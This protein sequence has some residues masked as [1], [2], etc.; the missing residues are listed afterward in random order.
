[1][2]NILIKVPTFIFFLGLIAGPCVTILLRNKYPEY[3]ITPNIIA[4]KVFQ[5]A[6]ILT[7]LISVVSYFSNESKSAKNNK[8]IYA[9]L[10]ISSLSS[11]SYGFAWK[12]EFLFD[13]FIVAY[14]MST[15]LITL[16]I[17]QVFYERS[18]W[19]IVLELLIILI[20]F[21]SLTQDLKQWEK[22][23]EIQW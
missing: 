8:L 7:W 15:V 3:Y 11:I 20:G 17:K 19:Y 18:T 13:L 2:R 10:L 1:M 5:W 21:I 12:N 4:L 23:K 6:V 22:N 9:L 14:I 16:K